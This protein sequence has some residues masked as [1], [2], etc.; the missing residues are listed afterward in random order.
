MDV[1][2]RHRELS[3][4]LY[5]NGGLMESAGERYPVINPATEDAIGDIAEATPHE[6][7]IAIAEAAA[8]Q[9]K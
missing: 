6:I 8:A 4:R 3:G 9:R 2:A 7:D 5:V 1:V